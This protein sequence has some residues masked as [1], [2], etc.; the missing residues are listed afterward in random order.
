MTLQPQQAVSHWENL[1]PNG[2]ALADGIQFLEMSLCSYWV[3]RGP[4]QELQQ[5]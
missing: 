2:Q 4:S 5:H 3:S 1:E